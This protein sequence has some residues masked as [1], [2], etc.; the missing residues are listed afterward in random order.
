MQKIYRLTNERTFNL[1]YRKGEKVGDNSLSVICLKSKFDNLKVAFVV[2]NKIGNAVKR[3]KIRRRLR[4]IFRSLIPNISFGY[5][6]LVVAR[7]GV[8]TL[9]YAQMKN[10]LIKLL[11]KSGKLKI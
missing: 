3:N 1:L 7:D 2:S 11:V 6:Y 10:C 8:K 4:E 5:T 9:S